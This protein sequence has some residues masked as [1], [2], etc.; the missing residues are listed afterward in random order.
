VHRDIKPENVM[1]RDDG[2]VKVLDFGVARRTIAGNRSYDTL[3]EPRSTPGSNSGGRLVG[4]PA[5]M[6]P[7]QIRGEPTDGR[8]DQF[9]WGVLAYELLTGRLPWKTAREFLGYIAA[10][11]T[12]KPDPPRTLAPEIPPQVEVAVLRALTKNPAN[13][14]PTIAAAAAELLP[15]AGDGL[16]GAVPAHDG[17]LKS[18]PRPP[19]EPPSPRPL[20]PEP[21][22]FASSPSAASQ[23]PPARDSAPAPLPR[24]LAEPTSDPAGLR[25]RP[26]ADPAEGAP[27]RPRSRL[28]DSG[29]RAPSDPQ[30]SRASS[31]PT[32]NR[33]S[34]PSRS[35]SPPPPAPGAEGA[36][37]TP[38]PP[39]RPSTPVPQMAS[40]RRSLPDGYQKLHDPRFDLPLD[41]EAHLAL[42]PRDATCKGLFFNDLLRVAAR[43]ASTADLCRAAQIEERRYVTFRDYP[44]AECLRLM[45]AVA[46][47]AYPKLPPGEALRRFGQAAFDGVMGTQVGR[48][49]LGILGSDVEKILLAV[50]KVFKLLTSFGKI[51]SEKAGAHTFLLRAKDLPAFLETYGVGAIEGMLRHCRMQGKIRV[52]LDDPGSGLCEVRLV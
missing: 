12:E 3:N 22:R 9:A 26:L 36:P 24:L 37:T 44:A 50:P 23:V 40:V 1:V 27:P 17:G 19:A 25:P 39:P 45:P 7:E 21:D 30:T 42:L 35:L 18:A 8:A 4:T 10:V 2:L 29:I 13:R 33:S 34:S 15:Y 51:T 16:T 32:L 20:P 11:L 46:R 43:V 28:E 5:Y 52:A 49:T 47:A 6:P 14:F 41:L 31:P 48:S 38:I